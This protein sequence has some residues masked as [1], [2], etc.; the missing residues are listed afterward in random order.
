VSST[1]SAVLLW[2]FV[3][4][5]GVAFGAGLYEHRVVVPTWLTSDPSGRHWRADVAR[6]DDVGRRFWGFVSTVPLTLITLANLLAA[7][8]ATGALRASWLTASGL[9]LVGRIA[10]FAYFIPSMIGLM[11]ADDSPAAIA[12]ASRWRTLNNVRLALSLAAWIVAMR[13]FSLFYQ[14]PS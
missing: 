10:T 3:I 7:W 5:L 14:Q 9:E 13:T 1:T 6:R 11:N 2:L 8:Q 12:T 4:N